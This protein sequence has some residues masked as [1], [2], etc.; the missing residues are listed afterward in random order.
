MRQHLLSIIYYPLS[1]ICRP[2]R[3]GP[4]SIIC[5]AAPQ[6]PCGT[7]SRA[8]FTL[9]EILVAVT[10]LLV[11]VV[12]G[13]MVFQETS[14]AFQ[15]GN[16]KVSGQVA[17]RNVLGAIARDLALAVDSS[18]YE[19]LSVQNS[20]N[21]TSAKFVALTGTP[22]F[23]QNGNTNSAIRTAQIINYSLGS[24]IVKRKAELL[25]CENGKWSK[26][27]G[28][29][30]SELNDKYNKISTLD[31]S[32]PVGYEPPIDSLLPWRVDVSASMADGVSF[33][34]VGAGS[35]GRRGWDYG[36]DNIYVGYEPGN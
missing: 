18:K 10:I 1:I 15:S 26:S 32:I 8:A 29:T 27:G 31:F 16:K 33:D 25:K 36:D 14:G 6:P 11:I 2:R 4:L 12:M 19:G 3:L 23:D 21:G 13:S 30:E 22:G 7:R 9:I 5:R 35:G 28:Y 17:V 34:S 24:G 20:F